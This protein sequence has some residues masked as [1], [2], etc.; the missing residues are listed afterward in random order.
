MT[1]I[2][3]LGIVSPLGHGLE[4]T[5]RALFAGDASGMKVESGW[6]PNASACVGRVM[7]ELPPLPAP[8]E[9]WDCRNNRLLAAAAAQIRP[10]IDAALA[11]HGAKRVALVIG[12]S[13]S[14]IASGEDAMAAKIRDGVFPP[15]FSYKQQEIG[16][17]AP[18]GARLLGVRGPAYTVSTACTSGA[19]AL[20]AARRLLDLGL[21]DAAIAGGVDTLCRLTVGGF[22]SLES[23][24]PQR[25]NPLSRNRNGINIG[26]GA[27]LFLLGREEA[28]VRLAGGGESSDAHHLSAPDPQGAG[29]ETAMRAALADAGAKP[30]DI[31]YV[32]LHATATRKNDEMESRVMARVFPA[33]TPVSGTKPLTGH[34]LG[35]AGALEAA[36]CWLALTDGLLPPHV[37]DG[38][39]DPELPA[40]RVAAKGERLASRMVMSNS[41]AFGGSNASLILSA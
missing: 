15:A 9:E 33:G 28:A 29:A 7:A 37:W 31:G 26:E 6:L 32:N 17:T 1:F 20:L 11:R 4:A 12:T 34:A 25:C 24:S 18:L 21:A 38:E 14:G 36:F 39:A 5:R 30:G 23:T 40:L 35:A 2:Q 13:T 10:A 3:A 22:A 16:A 41:F 8:L 27:A 19:K